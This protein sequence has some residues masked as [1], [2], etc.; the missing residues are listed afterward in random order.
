M[1]GKIIK[2]IAGFYYVHIESCGIY[3]CKAKG[4]FRN[5]KIKPLVGDNVIIDIIDNDKM[6]GNIIQ[7]LPRKNELIRP[8]PVPSFSPIS[9]AGITLVS[10]I[11]RQSPGLRY[12]VISLNILCSI[13]PVFLS[14]TINL[15]L[16][17]SD[18][19]SCAISSSGRS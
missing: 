15:E 16:E 4:I 13:A 3:E 9:L 1:Q 19:G 12:S 5:K 7:I 6:T 14:R 11:T 17:R 10:L 8:A 2:G 18:R